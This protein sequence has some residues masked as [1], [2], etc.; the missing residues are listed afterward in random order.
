MREKDIKILWGRSG[1]RC[2]IC[3]LELTP[4]GSRET[5]GEMAHIVARSLDG[6]RGLMKL[7]SEDRDCYDNLILLCPTHHSEVDKNPDV[8]TVERIREAK[9]DHEQWVSA[10]LEAGQ[11]SI[12]QVDNSMFLESRRS[13]WIKLA[14]GQV[15]IAVS[16]SPLRVSMEALEPLDATVVKALESARVPDGN[17]A[18]TEVNRYG[19]RPT[20]TGVANENF[21]DEG[22]SGHRIEIFRVGHCEYFLELGASV[23]Q[24]TEVAKSKADQIKDA[25]VV[26]YTDV[27]E[28]IELGLSWLWDIWTILPYT[29]MSLTVRLINTASTVLYSSEESWSGAK[30]GFTATDYHV[31]YSDVLQKGVDKNDVLLSALRRVANAYGLVLPSIHDQTGRYVRP[32]RMR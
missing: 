18:G 8:W 28:A 17:R 31:E 15:A 20:A 7:T 26:R 30:Y 16:L 22:G 21:R 14:R 3:K 32:Q 2:A 23:R 24:I 19:T 9:T 29:Y 5:L 13:A 11:I 10:R 12:Q 1:N 27:A 6:P 25:Q 4:D